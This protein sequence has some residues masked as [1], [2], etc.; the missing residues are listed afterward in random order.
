MNLR[1]LH[2][3]VDSLLKSLFYTVYREDLACHD[4]KAGLLHTVFGDPYGQPILNTIEQQQQHRFC[5][6]DHQ[7][8]EQPTVL[9]GDVNSKCFC[10][11]VF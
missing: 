7:H 2:A 4:Y 1:Y 11:F 6:I 8:L 3:T 9:K 10:I 5:H